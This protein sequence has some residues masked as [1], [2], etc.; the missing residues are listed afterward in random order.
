M[1]IAK[2][3]TSSHY[4]SYYCSIQIH[5]YEPYIHGREKASV[6]IKEANWNFTTL[7]K[8]FLYMPKFHWVFKV[9]AT[10]NRLIFC[11]EPAWRIPSMAK[12]MR[13]RPDGQRWDQNS[14]DPWTCSSIYPRTRICLIILCL[15]PALLTLAGVCPWR[16]ELTLGF[17]F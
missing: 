12:V 5:R 16:K 15:S 17:S 6:I 3:M 13:K 2:A 10:F 1:N 11:W 8:V 4:T 7:W 14:R 9:L